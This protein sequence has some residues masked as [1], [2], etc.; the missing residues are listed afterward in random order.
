MHPLQGVRIYELSEKLKREPN[1]KTAW[2]IIR[3]FY[4]FFGKD[5]ADVSLWHAVTIAMQADN[6]KTDEIER[7]NIL[8]FYEYFIR[9]NQ[10]VSFL[11]SEKLKEKADNSQ[12][13]ATE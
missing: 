8:F 6:D 9:L 12:G 7:G 4:D 13:A 5:Q 2:K 1:K 10:A 3:A 11:N